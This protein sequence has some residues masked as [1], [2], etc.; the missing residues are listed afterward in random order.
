MQVTK[1]HNKTDVSGDDVCVLCRLMPSELN[2]AQLHRQE[3]KNEKKL[4]FPTQMSR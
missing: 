3:K 4:R 1:Y 2:D